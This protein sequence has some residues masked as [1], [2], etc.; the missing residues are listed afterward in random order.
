MKKSLLVMSLLLL[1]TAAQAGPANNSLVVGSS[2][3]PP[4]IL[5]PWATNNLAIS[6]EING[7]LTAGLLTKDDDGELIPEIATRVP[8]LQN[9]DYKIVRGANGD[10]V[11][12]SVTFTIRREAKWSDGTPITPKDFQFWLRV[13]NDPRVPVP[14]RD[15][16]KDAKI[17]VNDADTFTVTFEPPYLFADQIT[18]RDGLFPA[19]SHIMERAFN[20]FDTATDK[21]D[22]KNDAKAINDQWQRFLAQYTT[23]RG[24]PKVFSGAFTLRTWRPGNSMTMARNTNY[25]R[26]PQGGADKYVQ[27][28]QYKF[29]PNTNTLKVNVLSGAIDALSAVGPTFD[30]GLDLQRNERGKFKTYFVPSAT[31]ERVDLNYFSSVTKVKDLDLDDKR[32]RQALLHAIDREGMVKSLFQG[33]QPVAHTWISPI[34]KLSKKDS[35]EYAFDPARARQLFAAAGWR[36]GPDGILTKNGKKFSL[37]FTTTSGN[38]LRE[39]IQQ[40]LQAQWKAVGVDVNI[41]NFPSTVVFANDFIA[42]ASEGKWDMFMYAFT[43]DPALE[44]GNLYAGAQIPTKD[45]GFSGQNN[46]GWKNAEYDKLWKDALTEFDLAKRVKMFDRMQELWSDEVAILPLYFRVNVYTKVPGLVNY[47]FSANNLYPSWNAYSMGWASRGAVEQ[48]K[49]K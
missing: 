48:Y 27:T 25:W 3:E 30:Q 5:D 11:R 43:S 19:P 36:P 42:R 49:Q 39:R 10:V 31:M 23:P 12:N 7:Y 4:T 34:S 13:Q 21:L 15:P 1:G 37:N 40:L 35:K 2:Q 46:V 16:W 28:V 33:K 29:I 9:G 24:M 32:V 14:S 20:A 17:T 22:P 18:Y 47:T 26:V 44:R 6:T 8:T 45:N 41:Q 38:V